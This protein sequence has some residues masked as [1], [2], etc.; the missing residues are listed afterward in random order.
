MISILCKLQI[1]ITLKTKSL[2]TSKPTIKLKNH[3]KKKKYH[4]VIKKFNIF[5][6]IIFL[7]TIDFLL[8][9]TATNN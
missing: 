9:T 3:L 7:L 5:Y 8:F 4:L 6:F 2:T 1:F